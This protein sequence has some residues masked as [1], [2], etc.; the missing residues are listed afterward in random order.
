MVYRIRY[1]EA[2]RPATAEMTVE[3]NSPSEAM[4]KFQHTRPRDDQRDIDRPR[5]TSVAAEMEPADMEK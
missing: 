5:V 1:C 4:V 2:F 3:A